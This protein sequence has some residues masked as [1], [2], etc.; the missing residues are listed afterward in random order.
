MKYDGLFGMFEMEQAV[1]RI[2]ECSCGK[3]QSTSPLKMTNQAETEGFCHLIE[4]GYLESCGPY[5]GVF[6]LT[7]AAVARLNSM[8]ANLGVFEP[9][10]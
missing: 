3:N 2:L 7:D 5:N 4:S 10:S 6:K 9:Q 1:R 8:G